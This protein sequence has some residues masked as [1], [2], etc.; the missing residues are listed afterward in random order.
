MEATGVLRLVAIAAGFSMA[1]FAFP[2][3]CQALRRT[4]AT[5]RVDRSALSGKSGIVARILRNGF[6]PASAAVQGLCRNKRVADYCAE[7]R[8]FAR[9]CGYETDSYRVGG[10]VLML[11]AVSFPVGWAMSSSPVFGLMLPVCLTVGLA[12][13]VRQARERQVEA[14]REAVPDM[15][16]ALSACFHAGY[17]LL[18]SFRHVANEKHGPLTPLFRRAESDLETGSTATE[19]LQRMREDS[20]LSELAF[21]TAALEIQHQTGGS[22]QKIID[23]ACDSIESELA[24]RRSLRVQTAQARL[25]MRIVTI[26]PFVLIAVFSLV[27]PGFLS[28]FFSSA[29]GIAVLCV[30]MGMQFAGVMIVR[31]ML[32]MGEA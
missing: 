15:L 8:W 13:A 19:A 10:V 27:S 26:M 12:I 14:M 25:S 31:H 21:V 29:V 23:S 17:S 32:D 7:L 5:N 28:P 1:A 6:A 2:G 20:A 30:A 11:S 9:N 3:A 18:Q 4:R 24:L 22:M 16:H